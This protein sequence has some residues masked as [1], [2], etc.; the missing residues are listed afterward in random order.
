M[1]VPLLNYWA[2][3]LIKPYCELCQN[4]SLFALAPRELRVSFIFRV[5]WLVL[6]VLTLLLAYNIFFFFLQLDILLFLSNF[7]IKYITHF[8]SILNITVIIFL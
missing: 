6:S 1:V 4:G 3:G 8:I 2:I 5:L 7:P